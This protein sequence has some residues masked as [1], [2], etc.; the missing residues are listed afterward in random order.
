[1]W[2]SPVQ[3]VMI[4]ITDQHIDYAKQ[5]AEELK[6]SGLRVEVDASNNR[7]NAKIRDAQL[8]KVPYMLVVGNQEV[9]AGTVAVRTRANEDRGAIPLAEFK[10]HALRLVEEKSLSL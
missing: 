10:E 7:M 2:L 9:S 6:Q 3:V 1:V 4:P 8:Q 5:V